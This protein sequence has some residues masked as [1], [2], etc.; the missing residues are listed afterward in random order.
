MS[1]ISSQLNDSEKNLFNPAVKSHFNCCPVVWMFCSRTS[2][3][4][5][6]KVHERDLILGDDLSDSLLQNNKNIGSHH[7]IIQSLMIEMFKIKNESAP[8][9]M[10][11]ILEKRNESYNIRNFQEFLTERKRTVH[12]GL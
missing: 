12:Y 5:I 2:N 7:K 3:N 10:N 4:M 8:P 6:N 9:I 1:R 11:S